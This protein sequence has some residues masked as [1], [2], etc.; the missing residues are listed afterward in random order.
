MQRACAILSSVACPSLQYFS[1]LYHNGTILG[2]KMLSIIKWV[3]QFS[4]ELLSET[5]LIL[6]IKERDMNRNAYRSSC[7]AGL[8]VILVRI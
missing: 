1:A 3:F 5:F 7:K 2:K 6:G 8:P 4:L